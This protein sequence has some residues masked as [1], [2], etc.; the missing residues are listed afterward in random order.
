MEQNDPLFMAVLASVGFSG[1]SEG[2]SALASFLFLRFCFQGQML[3]RS[4]LSRAT[5][6]VPRQLLCQPGRGS[7]RSAGRE[8][9]PQC[10]VALRLLSVGV[11]AVGYSDR[12][13]V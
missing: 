10:V 2:A 13:L 8:K 7:R 1:L 12:S 4:L 3:P 5:R 11:P 9:L 6:Q